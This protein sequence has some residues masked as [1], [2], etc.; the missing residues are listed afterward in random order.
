M[1][2]PMLLVAAAEMHSGRMEVAAE[3]ARDRALCSAPSGKRRTVRG[4]VVTDEPGAEGVYRRLR[5]TADGG[6]YLIVHYDPASESIARARAA[7]LGRQLELLRGLTGDERQGAQWYS[8]VFTNAANYSPPRGPSEVARWTIET[9]AAGRLTEAGQR[10]LTAVLPHEQVHLFQYRMQALP[11][12]WFLEGH[13]SWVGLKVSDRIDPAA[14]AADRRLKAEGAAKSKGQPLN[15]AG[16]GSV[17]PK[18]EAIMRQVSDED[19]A[20]MMRD[21]N[22][23]PSGSF[24]F[25][26]DDLIGDESNIV[27]RYHAATALFER[28][29]REHGAEAVHAF[30]RETTATAGRV[31]ANR[32]DELVR[33][34]FNIGADALLADTTPS[35]TAR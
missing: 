11:P 28:L 24:R 18:R 34:H 8:V 9:D 6:A 20:R 27:A 33:K 1:F 31:T 35:G 22:F 16:W 3:I 4:I 19:R 17:R 23:A 13:A 21:P 25:T 12:R 10:T 2:F 30:A 14:A 29:E 15:L 5:V 26:A 32:M 7:C